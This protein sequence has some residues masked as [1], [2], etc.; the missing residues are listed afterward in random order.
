MELAALVERDA[1]VQY[2]TSHPIS[3]AALLKQR[4]EDADFLPVKETEELVIITMAFRLLGRLYRGIKSVKATAPILLCRIKWRH[5][6]LLIAIF[7]CLF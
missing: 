6:I 3:H 7:Q 2:Y 4:D 5:Y 1:L